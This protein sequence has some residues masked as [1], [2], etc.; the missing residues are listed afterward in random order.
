MMCGVDWPIPD[1]IGLVHDDITPD[2]LWTGFGNR[3][4]VRDLGSLICGDRVCTR[5]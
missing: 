3:G 2:Y 4:P 5:W 1:W